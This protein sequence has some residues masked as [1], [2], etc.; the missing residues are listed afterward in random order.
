MPNVSGAYVQGHSATF[1]DAM[2]SFAVPTI[3][4]DRM[5]DLVL[6][7][8]C[9]YSLVRGGSLLTWTAQ[10]FHSHGGGWSNDGITLPGMLGQCH[11]LSVVDVYPD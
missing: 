7:K 3:L 10:F 6:L 2:Q 1:A 5:A 9:N 11:P 4:P 8:V